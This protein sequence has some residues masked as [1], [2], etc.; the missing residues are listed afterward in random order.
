MH[1]DTTPKMTCWDMIDTD[2][3][4]KGT[5]VNAHNGLEGEV[6]IVL[7]R[8]CDAGQIECTSAPRVPALAQLPYHRHISPVGVFVHR[9]S[10]DRHVS[11]NISTTPSCSDKLLTLRLGPALAAVLFTSDRWM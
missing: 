1:R 2:T 8:P 7:F 9:V 4:E 3:D 6:G 5:T 10:D 11:A